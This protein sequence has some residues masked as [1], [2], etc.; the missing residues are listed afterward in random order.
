LSGEPIIE[1]LAS[2]VNLDDPPATVN[3]VWDLQLQRTAYQK[4]VLEL[5]NETDKKTKNGNVMDAFIMPIAPFAAVSH[6]NYDHVS[7]TMCV[8]LL[9]EIWL[10]RL[11]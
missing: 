5:W 8:C 6:N 2:V 10:I 1:Q 11:I 4:K 3:E 9:K 7:Y